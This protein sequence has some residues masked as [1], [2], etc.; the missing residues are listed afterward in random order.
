M[1]YA[2]QL[3]NSLRWLPA[4][5]PLCAALALG[6]H[7]QVG[8]VPD[9]GGNLGGAGGTSTGTGGMDV[10]CTGASDPRMLVAPQRIVL[11]TPI[12]IAN[13]IRY[14]I[15]DTEANNVLNSGAYGIPA[16]TD[17][18]FPPSDGTDRTVGDTNIQYWNNMASDVS[19]YVTTNYATL[20]MKTANCNA[21]TDACA[22]SY[23]NA[24]A[25]KAYRRQLTADEQTRFT[26]LYNTLKNQM[27]NG[28]AVTTTV[29]EATGYAVWALLM[30]P[31]MV[32]R[33]E[34][35]GA[36]NGKTVATSNTPAGVYL[37]DDELASNISFFLTD[38]PPDDMLLAAAK[39]G[40][41]RANLASHVTRILGTTQARNW[42]RHVMEL[43][44]LLN[45]LPSIVLDTQKFPNF[46][47]T[48]TAAMQTEGQM[49]LDNVM[50]GSSS[51]LT[52]MLLTN[53]TFVNTKLAQLVYNIPVPSG[54]AVD[55]FVQAT[56]PSDQRAG[57]LTH[58]AFLTARSRADGQDL[59]SRGKTIKAAFLCLPT[60]PPT[61]MA[62]QMAVQAA[63]KTLDQQTGQEQAAS[64]AAAPVCKQCHGTF[65]AYGLVLEYFD[66]MAAY[67]TN[68][69]YLPNMPAIDGTTT[70]PAQV[71]GA[72]VHNAVELAQNLAN[73]PTFINCFAKSM[74]QYGVSELSASVD[75]P[76]PPSQS[77]CAA[78]DVV[79]RYQS[80]SAQTFTGLLTAVTQSPA[81]AVRQAAP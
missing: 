58:S 3:S 80:G 71:G 43:Y 63:S 16:D 66:A 64:R 55:K 34:V 37:S 22:T 27:V 69:S 5:L 81:F 29:Q 9:G 51:K 45:Q 21:V 17:L 25:A 72:T 30:S 44:F 56:L 6:C 53:T 41:L 74:L 38:N 4:A 36:E 8:D 32:W 62:T 75:L 40:T 10:P 79:S 57:I 15:D 73:S 33:W 78:A 7:G 35:G 14:L 24:L 67:R 68:Y 50:W 12:E 47:S 2:R 77:G 28:Y 13:T 39:A 18:H 23:L 19:T 42:M 46:D 20:A 1:R 60:A 61:D 65:D 49:F 59:I 52:D 54:A 31:Q 48:I 11:L 26:T 70:L 76:L